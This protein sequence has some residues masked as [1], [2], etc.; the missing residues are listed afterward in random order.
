MN[1][2][3]ARITSHIFFSLLK[4]K[5][6]SVISIDFIEEP[7]TRT[8]KIISSR[9]TKDGKGH[10]GKTLP[11]AGSPESGSGEAMPIHLYNLLVYRGG[12]WVS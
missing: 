10:E 12:E 1:S 2:L 5:Q 9:K 6:W 7:D 4:T 3:H 8:W 11:W